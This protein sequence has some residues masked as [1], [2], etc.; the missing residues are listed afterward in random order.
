MCHIGVNI[1][2]A[3][4]VT[5]ARAA[6]AIFPLEKLGMRRRNRNATSSGVTTQIPDEMNRIERRNLWGR[7]DS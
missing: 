7:S 3:T 5:T 4:V 1:V 6:F 2:V